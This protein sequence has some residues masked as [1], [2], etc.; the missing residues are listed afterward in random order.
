MENQLTFENNDNFD[1]ILIKP[2]TI[3]QLDWFHEDY[4]FNLTQLNCYEIINTNKNNFL[5][6]IANKLNLEKFKDKPGLEVT[7]QVI[8]EI[9]NYIYELIY[10]DE[11]TEKDDVINN[12]ATLLNTNGNKIY[13]NAFLIKTFI[14]SLSKSIL[15][16]NVNLNNIKEILDNRVKTNV[17]IYDGEWSNKIVTGNLEDFAKSFFDEE[18]KKFES[19][20]LL[21]NINIWY[22]ECDGCSTKS[23]GKILERPIYKCLWFTMITDEYRGSIYLDEVQ[24]I[25]TVSNNLDFPFNPKKEWVEDEMDEFSRKIIKNKYKVL[26]LAYHELNIII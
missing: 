6:L 18:Y 12:I 2:E 1:I 7:T 5:E 3:D 13:G 22:E 11:L 8:S 15:I 26:D 17:V 10:I 14:P 25:I 19:S 24:K 9:P 20:F 16:T 4:T 23:C 21:H